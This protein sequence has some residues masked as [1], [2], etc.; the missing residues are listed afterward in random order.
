MTKQRIIGT[1]LI[2]Q[3]LA[4]CDL[5]SIEAVFFASGVSSSLEIDQ[6]AFLRE[7]ELLKKSVLTSGSVPFFYFSTCSVYLSQSLYTPYIKHKIDMEDLV[8]DSKGGVVIR[9]PQLAG[10]SG[11]RSNLLRFF[12][13]S[14]RDNCPL[15]IR[16]GAERNVLDV[17]DAILILSKSMSLLPNSKILN[18]AKPENDLVANIVQDIE[19]FLGKTA[20]VN[21]AP[22]G[23]SYKIDTSHISDILNSMRFDKKYLESILT[24][25]SKYWDMT[26]KPPL[27]CR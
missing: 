17:E 9:L 13:E 2:A 4:A 8:L 22:G 14:I 1:G 23:D 10:R 19:K 25:Y 16:Q 15:I 12:Y 21:N 6:A 20:N 7:R 26:T 27:R 11:N 18:I 5:D 3:A 24:K